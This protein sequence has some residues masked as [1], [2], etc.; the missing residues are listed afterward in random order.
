MEIKEFD[1]SRKERVDKDQEPREGME[2]LTPNH[3]QKDEV[4][5]YPCQ[6]NM[7]CAC[8]E[9]HDQGV[10]MEYDPDSPMTPHN[11]NSEELY[12][13]DGKGI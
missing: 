2:P 8:E 6:V 13:P 7:L 10:D 4:M 12:F 1:G 5:D 11:H 9:D 3:S